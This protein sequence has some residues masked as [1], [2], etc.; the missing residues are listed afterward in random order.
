[1]NR[2][3]KITIA[4]SIGLLVITSLVLANTPAVKKW[5][6]P[7]PKTIL[8]KP[9]DNAPDKIDPAQQ[10]TLLQELSAWLKP[11]D[12]TNTSYYYDGLLTA[13]DRTDSAHA[14]INVDYR[15]CKNGNE[16]YLRIGNTETI[17]TKQV[18][19]FVD[20]EAKRIIL[21]RGKLVQQMPGIPV[22]AL[23]DYLKEEGYTLQKKTDKIHPVIFM[24][25]PNHI[26]CKEFTVQ[27]DSTAKQVRKIFF[28][29]ADMADH[30]DPN[31]E[32]WVTLVFKTWNDQPET[33]N[34]L[35]VKKFITKQKE[36]WIC[37]PSYQD[38]QLMIR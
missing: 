22:N 17:N 35:Q 4:L 30:M 28:R 19:L 33:D 29:Q 38:Y 34:Y 14:M 31:L 11:F 23:Y 8:E 20:H 26:S 25:N 16:F 13:I 3:K 6:S 24:D 1:M 2:N 18:Y 10:L 5:W 12:S 27:Y 37:T 36:E 7:A 21:N 15:F 32:K 9:A